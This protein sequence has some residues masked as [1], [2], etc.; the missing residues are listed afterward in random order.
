MAR[1]GAR[2][3]AQAAP[4]RPRG[5]RGAVLSWSRAW[6]P[7]PSSTGIVA[8]LKFDRADDPTSPEIQK[9]LR[10]QGVEYVMQHYMSLQPDEPLYGMILKAWQA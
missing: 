8:A 3:G 10:E 9:A 2:S 1:V 6:I 4:E 5:G 7:R